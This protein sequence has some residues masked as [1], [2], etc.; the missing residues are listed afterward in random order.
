VRKN[1][2]MNKLSILQRELV[3]TPA[4]FFDKEKMS[5]EFRALNDFLYE[6]FKLTIHIKGFSNSGRMYLT[7]YIDK[8]FGYFKE[9]K[10]T[11]FGWITGW[12]FEDLMYRLC[13]MI[14]GE[15]QMHLVSE[16]WKTLY[17]I[18][19]HVETMTLSTLGCFYS[20][21]GYAEGTP[22]CRSCGAY[23]PLK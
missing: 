5:N 21:D 22:K 12:K 10:L 2:L 14:I 9:S 20:D 3:I 13:A 23:W 11:E 17:I 1:L 18:N 4:N 15:Q 19:Y 7:P 8:R 16:D 6:S